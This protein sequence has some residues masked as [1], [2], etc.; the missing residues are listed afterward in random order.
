MTRDECEK[1]IAEKLLEARDIY[2]QYYNGDESVHLVIS[3]DYV[4][5]FNEYWLNENRAM[6]FIQYDG[7]ELK[8]R[9]HGKGQSK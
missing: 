1:Q 9:P 2:R 4:S 6:D 5:A 7:E 3:R 8:S